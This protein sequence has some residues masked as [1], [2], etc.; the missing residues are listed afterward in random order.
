MFFTLLNFFLAIIVDAFVE[1]K[2]NCGQLRCTQSF[3]KDLCSMAGTLYLQRR[4]KLPASKLLVKFLSESLKG[5]EAVPKGSESEGNPPLFS[6]EA[7]RSEFGLE[8]SAVCHWL[9]RIESMSSV[10]FV[11][12]QH[13]EHVEDEE[14]PKLAPDEQKEVVEVQVGHDE[15]IANIEPITHI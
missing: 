9:C 12:V 6:A 14:P 4:Y 8:E 5:F 15:N 13:Q 3:F 7:I 1:V 10:P 2:E 11:Q